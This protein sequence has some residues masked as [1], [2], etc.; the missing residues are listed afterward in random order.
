MIISNNAIAAERVVNL[1]NTRF[2]NLNIYVSAGDN[3]HQGCV[4]EAGVSGIVQD[5]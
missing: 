3:A 5:T 1:L 4:N 2:S